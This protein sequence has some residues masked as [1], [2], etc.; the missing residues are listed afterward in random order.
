M[1]EQEQC[2]TCSTKFTSFVKYGKLTFNTGERFMNT[3][4]CST[5]IHKLYHYIYHPDSEIQL[6]VMCYFCNGR[7]RGKNK[8]MCGECGT[9][10]SQLQLSWEKMLQNKLETIQL[11]NEKLKQHISNNN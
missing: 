6:G 10:K 2:A 3:N 8:S 4:K 9:H 7:V 11:Q 1:S 5:C